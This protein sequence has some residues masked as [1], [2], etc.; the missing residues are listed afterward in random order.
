MLLKLLR[1]RPS[2]SVIWQL[3]R[4]F[5]QIDFIGLIPYRRL[6]PFLANFVDKTQLIFGC[7]VNKRSSR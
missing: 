1:I 6:D 2:R 5:I 7:K 3:L 4:D